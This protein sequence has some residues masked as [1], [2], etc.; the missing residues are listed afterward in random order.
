MCKLK[1]T[2]KFL[3]NWVF[4]NQAEICQKGF[5]SAFRAPKPL[6]AS[7]FHEKQRGTCSRHSCFHL[8]L[9]IRSCLKKENVKKVINPSNYNLS[10]GVNHDS[11]HLLKC[12][13]FAP[14]WSHWKGNHSDT[15]KCWCADALKNWKIKQNRTH[16]ELLQPDN[17]TV[18]P[19]AFLCSIPSSAPNHLEKITC[20]I[21][22]IRINTKLEAKIPGLVKLWER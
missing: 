12:D 8:L 21:F 3:K 10:R 17:F 7:K 16:L 4:H 2:G 15:F 22:V 1:I 18:L 11:F 20:K 19:A 9:K 5:L 13:N 14:A 6:F